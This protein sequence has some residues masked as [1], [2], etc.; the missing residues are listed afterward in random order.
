M[1]QR[2]SQ[3]IESQV[4]NLYT[5]GSGTMELARS[6]SLSRS[7]VQAI[8]KRN[9]ITLRKTSPWKNR[10]DINFFDKYNKSSCYWAGFILADGCIRSE[11]STLAV[12]LAIK[13]YSHLE[14]MAQAISFTGA[15][16]KNKTACRLSTNGKW[17]PAALKKNFSI[18]PRKSLTA[19]WPNIPKKYWSHF[20]RGIM[21]G[22]GCVSQSSCPTVSFVGTA[23]LMN[24]LRAIFYEEG[25]RLKS[26]NDYPSLQ[27][28]S[29]NA[30]HISYS[31]Q[32]AKLILNWIYADSD[33]STRLTRKYE[34]YEK[35][36]LLG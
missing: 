17:H 29:A 27:Q 22:D 3:L 25:V 14:K 36:F 16:E 28:T 18:T 23:T 9:D 15:I 7:T 26:K 8:L 19:S 24:S 6:F 30:Y 13:D 2:T 10:Y 4:C 1:P 33:E 5:N 21:D 12:H 11:R 34:L 31:G 20:I 35:L 32:N